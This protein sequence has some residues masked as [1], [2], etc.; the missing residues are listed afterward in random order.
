MV[1]G[2]RKW[3]LIPTLAFMSKPNWYLQKDFTTSGKMRLGRTTCPALSILCKTNSVIAS[4]HSISG[5]VLE[6]KENSV[7]IL[8]K[9]VCY[10]HPQASFSP[11]E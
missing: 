7:R 1:M 5:E 4:N 10:S 8:N 3:T 2:E 6:E 9:L 11:G